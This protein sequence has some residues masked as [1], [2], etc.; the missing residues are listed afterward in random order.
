[1]AAGWPCPGGVLGRCGQGTGVATPGWLGV[2][3][4]VL[5]AGSPWKN[6]RTLSRTGFTETSIVRWILETMK[7]SHAHVKSLF[8]IKYNY[9]I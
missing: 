3:V 6:G 1:M 5:F 4:G 9:I 2:L 7:V 8:V